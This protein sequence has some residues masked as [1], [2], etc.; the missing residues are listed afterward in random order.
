M[1]LKSVDNVFFAIFGILIFCLFNV[2]FSD[3]GKATAYL[4][5]VIKKVIIVLL[6]VLV[7]IKC[8]IDNLK[9]DL[10]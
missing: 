8:F 1:K 5:K 10:A 6:K 2:D 4:F 3:K 9:L 7:L